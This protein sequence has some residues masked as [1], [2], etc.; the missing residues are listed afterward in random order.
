MHTASRGAI[1]DIGGAKLIMAC[2]VVVGQNWFCLPNRFYVK[3]RFMFFILELIQPQTKVSKHKPPLVS[4]TFN[5]NQ[6]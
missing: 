5:Q 2:L 4:I 3:L 1:I 6:L